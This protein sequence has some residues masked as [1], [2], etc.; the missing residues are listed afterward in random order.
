MSSRKKIL[1]AVLAATLIIL[2]GFAWRWATTKKI[3]YNAYDPFIVGNT[4]TSSAPSLKDSDADGL[5]D[6]E[7]VLWGTDPNNPD[8]D[9]DSVSDGEEV[10]ENR[11]PSVSGA[12][13]LPARLSENSTAQPLS[14]SDK[15]AQEILST[16][17]KMKAASESGLDTGVESSS[18]IISKNVLSLSAPQYT[19][20]QLTTVT[21]SPENALSFEQSF[22]TIFANYFPSESTSE[23]IVF[24]RA[25]QTGNESDFA[26]LRDIASRYRL[27]I[28]DLLALPVP[29]P[30]AKLHISF[31]NAFS[32]LAPSIDGMAGVRTDTIAGV[33][34]LQAYLD[35]S[36]ITITLITEYNVYFGRATQ[37]TAP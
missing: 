2:S 20:N 8:S 24:K 30:I 29:I 27:A 3:S 23:M 6:W 33:R 28:K 32:Y 16:Y 36:D 18:S 14:T 31:V 34:A 26:A 4:G 25:L 21:D 12:G 5:A 13:N 37:S 35:F 1:L 11:D 9:G 10:K 19:Q 7:E 17:I 15:L 22:Y